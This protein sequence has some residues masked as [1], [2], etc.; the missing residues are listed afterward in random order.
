MSVL[1]SLSGYLLRVGVS[2]SP[3]YPT[4]LD[5]VGTHTVRPELVEGYRTVECKIIYVYF[6]D[7]RIKILRNIIDPSTSSGRTVGDPYEALER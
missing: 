7:L 1:V 2:K 5:L 3:F 4:R 6:F